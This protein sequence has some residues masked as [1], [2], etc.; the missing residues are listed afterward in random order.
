MVNKEKKVFQMHIF[1][2]AAFLCFMAAMILISVLHTGKPGLV[3]ENT[4]TQLLRGWI[5][6]TT[7]N[8]IEG[9]RVTV[10]SGSF[11]LLKRTLPDNLSDSTVIGYYDQGFMTKAYVAGNKMYEAGDAYVRRIGE[12]EGA[13]W[14]IIPLNHQHSGKD[15][16]IA[17]QNDTTGDLSLDLSRVYIGTESDIS[18]LIR[19]SSIASAVIMVICFSI[20]AVLLFFSYILWK[21]RFNHYYKR[22]RTLGFMSL[23]FGVWVFCD[24]NWMQL[25]IADSSVRYVFTYASFILLPAL[26]CQYHYDCFEEKEMITFKNLRSVYELVLCFGILL[27]ITNTVHISSTMVLIH[28]FIIIELFLIGHSSFSMYKKEKTPTSRGQ[29]ISFIL[30]LAFAVMGMMLYY[31]NQY[32][33]VSVYMGI[34]YILF[35]IVLVVT[36]VRHIAKEY[37]SETKEKEFKSLSSVESVTRGNSRVVVNDWL[38]K[39]EL[40][41]NGNP[42]FVQMDLVNFSSINL[43]LGWEKGNDILRGIYESNMELVGDGELQASIGDSNFVFLLDSKRDIEEFCKDASRKLQHY[44]KNE[45][46]GVYLVAKYSALR[47]QKNVSL[48]TMLD[49]CNLAFESEYAKYDKASNCYFFT[50]EC[51]EEVKNRYAL[52]NR[53]EKALENDEFV[54][55][56]Q[57]KVNPRTNEIEG[58]EALIRWNSPTEGLI[59]PGVFIPIAEKSGQIGALDLKIFRLVCEYLVERKEKD[60]PDLRI[61]VNVSKHDIGKEN[62]FKPYEQIINETGVPCENLEFEFTESSAFEDIKSI[63]NII[64]RIHSMGATVSMDDFGS[65]FS[66]LGAIAKLQFDVLKMDKLF[67]DKGF[68]SDERDYILVKGVIGVFHNMGIKIVCE[69]VETREQKET[70]KGLRAD[71]I[72]GFYY[73]RPMPVNEFE[74]FIIETDK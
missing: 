26:L 57:P 27:Y 4:G 3:R 55:F 32:S 36:Q 18:Y 62:F 17:L 67:F 50:A 21:G 64:S 22:I 58:A 23:C 38:E 2:R 49:H 16:L 35:V 59:S 8:P 14:R 73:A 25:Y 71:L 44:M 6:A 51:E 37:R 46:S 47:V 33:K 15:I 1:S 7:F 60:L 12:E 48:A 43:A 19:S 13:V 72:Q 70:L 69:G 5:D 45:W 30:V 11:I 41:L 66:N 56:L 9:N 39:E 53:I 65:S 24:G 68:P 61:S 28:L 42:W 20:A 31:T 63:E 10:K 40:Y 74:G 52:E 54:L 34:G 29:L